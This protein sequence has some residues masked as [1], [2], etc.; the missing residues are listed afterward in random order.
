MI[1]NFY[2]SKTQYG[3]STKVE[4]VTKVGNQLT[5]RHDIIQSGG[6]NLIISLFNTFLDIRKYTKQIKITNI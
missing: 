2:I 6:K 3:Y 1:Q 4:I 5:P